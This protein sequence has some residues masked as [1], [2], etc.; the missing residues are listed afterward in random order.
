[1]RW[2][3]FQASCKNVPVKEILQDKSLGQPIIS[4]IRFE[5]FTKE[6]FVTQA[7]PL[8]VL[9]QD[10]LIRYQSLF[11]QNTQVPNPRF[12]QLECHPKGTR[13]M[14]LSWNLPAKVLEEIGIWD[15]QEKKVEIFFWNNLKWLFE[16]AKQTQGKII[17][18]LNVCN[19]KVK[20]EFFMEIGQLFVYSSELNQE[21]IQRFGNNG[22]STDK[23]VKGLIQT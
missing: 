6:Q 12:Y 22:K 2:P 11:L 17:F 14:S 4:C 5:N 23:Y 1:M 3:K 7:L 16:I 18:G 13:K 9:S 19:T 15:N 20:F 10:Q 8:D 21:N